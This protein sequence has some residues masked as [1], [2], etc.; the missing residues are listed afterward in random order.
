[1]QVVVQKKLP[2]G[3]YCVRG[4]SYSNDS[5]NKLIGLVIIE[6]KPAILQLKKQKYEIINRKTRGE[7]YNFK[8]QSKKRTISAIIRIKFIQC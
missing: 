4:V 1:M 6:A 2:H 3:K 7:I 8:L 5:N